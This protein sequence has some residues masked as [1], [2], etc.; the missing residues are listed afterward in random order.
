MDDKRIEE[1]LRESCDVDMPQGM[2]DRV[3]R[4]ARQEL[5]HHNS[6]RFA[7]RWK[8]VLV[9]MALAIVLLTNIMDGLTQAHLT[10]LVG[11]SSS[12]GMSAPL[13]LRALLRQHNADALLAMYT[14]DEST[15]LPT[16]DESL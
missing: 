2:K 5:A 1:I 7:P 6:R 4:S 9:S 3:M 15:V 8:P 12:I 11:G 14:G 10:K 13:D 16:G